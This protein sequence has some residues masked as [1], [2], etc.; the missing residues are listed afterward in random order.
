MLVSWCMPSLPSVQLREISRRP[1][2]GILVTLGH[3]AK[4]PL[5]QIQP[6]LA[7]LPLKHVGDVFANDGDEFEPVVGPDRCDKKV[8][9]SAR[10]WTDPK[11]QIARQGVPRA[12][13]QHENFPN[14]P[15]EGWYVTI[16]AT[17]H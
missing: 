6:L 2:M 10:V 4:L 17:K 9:C 1:W 16:F 11:V 13:C 5:P 15:L 14:T 8:L 12:N 3:F 7:E